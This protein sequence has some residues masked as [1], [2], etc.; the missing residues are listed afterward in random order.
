M[1]VEWKW[2]GRVGVEFD[3]IVIVQGLLGHHSA[4]HKQVLFV[5]LVLIWFVLLF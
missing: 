5:I 1:C 2:K 3:R 4:G